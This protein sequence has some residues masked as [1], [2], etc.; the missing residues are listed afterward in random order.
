MSGCYLVPCYQIY[1]N[2]K[3]NSSISNLLNKI[4]NKN[5]LVFYSFL[6][7][8]TTICYEIVYRKDLYSSICIFFVLPGIIPVIIIN[9]NEII[10]SI[11][12]FQVFISILCFMTR[13]CVLYKKY[14]FLIISLFAEYWLFFNIALN[15]SK[16]KNIFY[17]ELFFISNFAF[18]YI[19]LHF[20]F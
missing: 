14:I 1:L 18:Y 15:I 4:E 7:G 17:N 16:N 5:I 12:A 11:F 9:E 20:I 19:Y 3:N 13:N 8:S 10:H 6:L 2:Y